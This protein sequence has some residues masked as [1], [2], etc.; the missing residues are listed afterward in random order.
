[1]AKKMTLTKTWTN[2]LRLWR[3]I[4]IKLLDDE[5]LD[6]EIL[7]KQQMERYSPDVLHVN[8]CF[9]CDYA[10]DDEG[11]VECKK[12]PA[13]L[14]DHK[15]HCTKSIYFWRKKPITFHQKLVVLNKK[16]KGKKA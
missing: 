9:F 11:W 14:I 5:T 2:C 12:C 7:K 1:M 8:D 6:V 3:H 15:F 13:K 10:L 4:A 16:R